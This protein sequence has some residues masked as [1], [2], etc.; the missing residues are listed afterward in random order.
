MTDRALFDEL[1]ETKTDL[2]DRV[3]GN[4]ISSVSEK[5]SGYGNEIPI[6]VL[7]MGHRGVYMVT[8]SRESLERMGRFKPEDLDAWANRELWHTSYH[9]EFPMATGAGDTTIAGM[10]VAMH[11][12]LSPESVLE[13]G[14][15]YGWQCVGAPDALGGLKPWSESTTAGLTKNPLEVKGKG[16]K[17]VGGGLYAGPR[18]KG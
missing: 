4:Q 9:A 16:W 11:M 15:L 13:R 7:K 14:T 17:E 3:D 1:D 10:H 18:N 6:I 12:G 5:L 8:G 2:V